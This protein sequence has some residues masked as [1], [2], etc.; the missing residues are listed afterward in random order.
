VANVLTEKV[1]DGYF[2]EIEAI[3]I[4]RM[5]FHDNAVRILKLDRI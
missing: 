3:T 4:S 1:K 2:T 5:L